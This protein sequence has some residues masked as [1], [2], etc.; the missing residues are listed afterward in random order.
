MNLTD[1][2]KLQVGKWIDQGLKVADI[3]KLLGSEL[4]LSMTYMEVRFLIDDLKLAP[5]DP[6]PPPAPPTPPPEATATP[7]APEEASQSKDSF[8]D[9]LP[10]ELPPA[11][12]PAPDG[13]GNV[14]VELNRIAIPGTVVSGS[15]VFSDGKSAN[16]FL[17]QFGRL[18]LNSKEEGYKP[19][20]QDLMQFQRGL[21]AELAKMGF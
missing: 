8:K 2:Q 9:D 14:T 15:V 10:E 17:D 1:A 5:K 12:E 4:K 11:E 3:Q 21:Q 18:G 20:Q 13:G 6:T 16:W 19:S 7:D